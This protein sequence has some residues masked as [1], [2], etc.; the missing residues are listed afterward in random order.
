V[1]SR[2]RQTNSE[3]SPLGAGAARNPKPEGVLGVWL[4]GAYGGLATTVITGAHAVAAGL[5]DTTG[6]ATE[7][8]PLRQL[9]L[10]PLGALRFGGHD[11]RETNVLD[12]VR[13]LQREN[14]TIPVGWLERL[15]RP[16]RAI[17]KDITTGTV[18]NCGRAI[19]ALRGSAPPRDRLSLRAV[20]R[21]IE[22]DV[23]GFM[24][25]HRLT[26]VVAVNVASTEP[27]LPL[28]PAHRSLAQLERA[29]DQ[30]RR[31]SV[32]AS[33]L[34]SYAF[35]RLG[36]PYIQF[37]ASNAALV[38]AVTELFD[39]AG[40]PYA[41]F[42]GKSGETL[43]KSALAPMFRHR[44]LRVLTWQGYNLLGDR[45]GV[46]LAN[47]RNRHAK[48]AT[49]DSILSRVLGYPLHTHVA[50]DFVPSLKDHKTAWDFV[51]FEGFLGFRMAMQFTWQG[52]DA[53]LA[54]PLVLDLIRLADF[55]ARCGERGALAHLAP[56]FK[57]PLGC[58]AQDLPTQWRMLLDYAATR[59]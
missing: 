26:R 52:C 1:A 11:I 30:D 6:L 14:G 58:A 8:E 18:I 2:R 33:L 40:A 56:Y 36:L 57:H 47:A 45:D 21:S 29:I 4:V 37:T 5:A 32:R 20:V 43:V 17:D 59:I 19:R 55:A 42:D 46:V 7:T 35:A 28:G 22:N 54:A 50:I 48:V 44:N 25:R 39:R 41:G 15:A 3:P 10:Q 53:I 23:R 9:H 31:G 13:E 34:Y 12:S 27:L 24:R 51:H 16:L 49:K 38:P